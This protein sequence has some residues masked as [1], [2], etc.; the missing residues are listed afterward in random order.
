MSHTFSLTYP[1]QDAIPTTCVL[2]NIGWQG[3]RKGV[4]VDATSKK[5]KSCSINQTC[6]GGHTNK[7][8]ICRQ[9]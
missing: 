1:T 6:C 5:K 4:T 3:E 2:V 7:S 9:S 8:L